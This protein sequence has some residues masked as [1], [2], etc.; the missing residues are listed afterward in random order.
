MLRRR[1][2]WSSE[3]RF[4]LAGP[5]EASMK[6][7]WNKWNLPF[8]R[9]T[10]STTTMTSGWYSIGHRAKDRKTTTWT[11]WTPTTSWE[12]W[13]VTANES[14]IRGWRKFTSLEWVSREHAKEKRNSW[15]HFAI[16]LS[17]AFFVVPNIIPFL[18]IIAIQAG[19]A[20]LNK[21]EGEN[22]DFYGIMS[23]RALCGC[24]TKFLLV[25]FHKFPSFIGQHFFAPSLECLKSLP[26]SCSV[27]MSVNEC[28]GEWLFW[29]PKECLIP[30]LIQKTVGLHFTLDLCPL[31]ERL[32]ADGHDSEG[33]L[34]L[35]NL[36]A[37][38]G[39]A[40][41][42]VTLKNV[43]RNNILH[44]LQGYFEFSKIF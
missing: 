21:G 24:Q 27:Y 23:E 2:F 1:Q 30:A 36:Y 35:R 7:D 29:M 16:F 9:K 43:R 28:D 37:T 42:Q 26:D 19:A 14:S 18:R 41:V 6:F 8:C 31:F 44:F 32:S 20:C 4:Q 13:P 22:I 17:V 33:K 11:T 40:R 5:H 34:I 12:R 3:Y 10:C 38:E 15:R 25:H 39:G